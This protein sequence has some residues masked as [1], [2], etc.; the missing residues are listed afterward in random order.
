MKNNAEA[1]T[2]FIFSILSILIII[3]GVILFILSFMTPT[4]SII[5]AIL[6]F[7][8]GA[9][10]FNSVKLYYSFLEVISR[11]TE[12]IES[13]TKNTPTNQGDVQIIKLDDNL[14]SEQIEDLKTKF[15]LFADKI[16]TVINSII[17]KTKKSLSIQEM[18]IEQLSIE[19]QKNIEENKFEKAAEIRDE[20]NKRKNI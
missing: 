3:F 5:N 15:P 4:V 18:S 19:L 11:F 14:S 6:I 9:I 20:I 13:L 7:S 2:Q 10:L 16:E 1:Y 8:G 17:P 12:L